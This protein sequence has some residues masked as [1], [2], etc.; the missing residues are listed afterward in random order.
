MYLNLIFQNFGVDKNLAEL[1]ILILIV[2]LVSGVF[3]FFIGRFH[4]YDFLVNIYVSLAFLHV[5]PRDMIVFSKYSYLF[6]FF[7][8][9]ILL[10][11]LNKYIFCI[12]Q[13][14]NKLVTWKVF[15]M[16]LLEIML[17]LSITFS[18]LA[19]T[20]ALKYISEKYLVYLIDPWWKLFWMI[21]PL[22]F[23]IFARRQK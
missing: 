1:I 4:I 23:L 16:S 7:I 14:N 22:L 12:H 2:L 9:V 3:W 5:I 8:F 15:V 18:F 13:Y 19:N 6:I 21:M 20:E 11:L 17:L 10:T